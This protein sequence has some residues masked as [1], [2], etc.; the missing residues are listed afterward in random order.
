MRKTIRWGAEWYSRNRLEGVSRYLLWKGPNEPAIFA[1][2][3]DA[4]A[5]VAERYGYIRHRPDL[6]EEPHGWRVPR[7]IRVVV[8]IKPIRRVGR[9]R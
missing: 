7:A 5:W 8:D 3:S 2:R 1:T 4:R 6:R 9:S